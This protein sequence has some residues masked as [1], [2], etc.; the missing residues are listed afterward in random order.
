MC[1]RASL[2][3]F[4]N[5]DRRPDY[6]YADGVTFALYELADG[7]SVTATVPRPSHRRTGSDADG[8]PGGRRDHRK[9]RP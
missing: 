8:P 5:N 9:P 7:A 1:D 4:G 2:V 6:D 3:A